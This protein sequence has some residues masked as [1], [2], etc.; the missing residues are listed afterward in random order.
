[1][2]LNYANLEKSNRNDIFT[3]LLT[4]VILF[5]ILLGVFIC[6]QLLNKH[7][8]DAET[9]VKEF[10][11]QTAYNIHNK[12]SADIQFLDSV[13][14]YAGENFSSIK[15]FDGRL[16]IKKV[17]NRNDFKNWGISS[18]SGEEYLVDPNGRLIQSG[19]TYLSKAC[20]NKVSTGGYCFD[21][22][23]ETGSDKDFEM[24]DSIYAV[25][26]FNDNEIKAVLFAVTKIDTINHILT[27][28]NFNNRAH[29]HIIKSDGTFFIKDSASMFKRDKN[30]FSDS[31]K[32]LTPSKT[33]V[34][35]RLKSYRLGNYW[36]F[37]K[38]QI[39]L[40]TFVPI[41][42]D[43][44]F[45][46]IS[47]PSTIISVTNLDV[48]LLLFSVI[49][50][51]FY[52][53]YIMLKR[54]NVIYDDTHQSM[55]NFAFNDDV[56]GAPNSNKFLLE[57]RKVFAN[58]A[59]DNKKYAMVLM[60]IAKFK[61]I[62]EIYG[63]DNANKIL[64]DVSEIIRRN[65]R[66]TDLSTRYFAAT[67]AFLIKYN[68]VEDI[69][70]TIDKIL[71]EIDVY[72]S[73]MMT[74]FNDVKRGLITKLVLLF[75]VYL[76]SDRHLSINTMCDRAL[77]AKRTIQ[78]KVNQHIAFY[79]E[80]LRTKLLNDKKI[81]DEMYS[82]LEKNEFVMYLQP[83]FDMHTL[84]VVGSEALV[85]WIHPTAGFIPPCDFIPLFEQNGFVVELDHYI[86]EVACKTIRKWMNWGLNPTP[87]SV[88]VSRLH[89]SN[90]N[91][92]DYL[93]HLIKK[94]NIPA[95]LLELELTESACFD[96]LDKFL[97]ILNTLKKY[98]FSIAMDDFGVGYSSLNILRKIPVDILKLDKE[99]IT[100]STSDDKGKVVV[101]H[102]L[103]MAKNLNLTTV[104]E[105]IE[106]KEQA[107]FLTVAGCDIAQGF[108]FAR[109]MPI[110]DFEKLAFA[111]EIE[112]IELQKKQNEENN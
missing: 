53:L 88:N 12:I 30:I 6:S 24:F 104:S 78:S 96:D 105:G 84:K 55:M 92:I 5:L 110:N 20:L 1:M 71:A 106:T 56:T 40:N 45:V 9:I 42:Y 94:Y 51:I 60:D 107:E 39:W 28:D 108:L 38:N 17:K 111:Q 8:N 33:V 26:I 79:D 54:V 36:S 83:K 70:K 100:T 37:R 21:R 27:I 52:L 32:F 43:N 14:S 97:E 35:K 7:I 91:F 74:N 76:V 73:T 69:S 15:T 22:I 41:N 47:V 72:N 46:E 68:E 29:A 93:I 95:Q 61:V 10:T 103:A 4:V 102:V 49:I 34:E 3:G 112:Q 65:I 90:E 87:I 48:L 64:K 99:F 59:N 44:W 58:P 57:A 11:V 109:P 77:L 82:A 16:I 89:L 67:F 31:V 13:S 86:W 2:Q 18:L 80:A 66:T 50:I 62:N 85:R 23:H 98:G 75:G 101:K 63:Y 19:K 81:E 25:P